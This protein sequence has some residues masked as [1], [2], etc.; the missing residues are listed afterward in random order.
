MGQRFHACLGGLGK[1]VETLK[2]IGMAR[3]RL[4][5][6]AELAEGVRQAEADL[7][8]STVALA[9]SVATKDG[10]AVLKDLESVITQFRANG[11]GDIFQ[12]DQELV[13]FYRGTMERIL[14]QLLVLSEQTLLLLGQKLR[15]QA[16]K[17]TITELRQTFDMLVRHLTAVHGQRAG[18]AGRE[19]TDTELDQ[20]LAERR[21][22][23]GVVD[24]EVLPGGDTS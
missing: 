23:L 6:F 13:A 22:L 5:R 9:G 12:N 7:K 2:N 20:Q 1:D 10:A 21:K 8:A 3:P 24:G 4:T 17:V 16:D 15:A 19:L 11:L 18:T 14:G